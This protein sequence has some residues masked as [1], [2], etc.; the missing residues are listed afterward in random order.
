MEINLIK[1][2]NVNF[3]TKNDVE[4]FVWRRLPHGNSYQTTYHGNITWCHY[5]NSCCGF[6]YSLGIIGHWL[7]RQWRQ[8]K[9]ST[10]PLWALPYGGLV[11]P[12]N[13]KSNFW[14]INHDEFSVSRRLPY[15]STYSSWHRV[16]TMCCQYKIRC[17]GVQYSPTI[18][19]YCTGDGDSTKST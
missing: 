6:Q 12:K 15:G 13:S 7:Y 3:L 10:C 16:G 14:Q 18:V 11:G 1:S 8:H 17:F 4:Y 5:S 19:A 9:F 2:F